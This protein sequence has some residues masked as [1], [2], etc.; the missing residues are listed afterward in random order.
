MSNS[1][2]IDYNLSKISELD[3]I[4]EENNREKN[5][6][7]EYNNK[8]YNKFIFFDKLL[9]KRFQTLLVSI[10]TITIFILVIDPFYSILIS[11]NIISLINLI[12]NIFVN[13]FEV[14]EDFSEKLEKY[15]NKNDELLLKRNSYVNLYN[16]C[17]YGE[18]A[19]Y[20][21]IRMMINKEKYYE[22]E[23]IIPSLDFDKES[24]EISTLNKMNKEEKVLKESIK[25][26][27][28]WELNSPVKSEK[29]TNE[30]LKMIDV[31]L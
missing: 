6:Y 14:D 5:K 24:Y 29:L 31:A 30:Q 10:I 11:L 7:I 12:I 19:L 15:K 22:Y 2:L 25:N 8:K 20:N 1:E 13:I 3:E 18:N 16:Y 4:I 9:S 21:N 26:K 23:K 28:Y 17:M 27:V